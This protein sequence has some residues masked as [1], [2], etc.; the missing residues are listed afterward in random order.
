MYPYGGEAIPSCCY[1]N[2][3]VQSFIEE[4][5]DYNYYDYQYD[6]DSDYRDELDLNNPRS[7]THYN[8]TVGEFVSCRPGAFPLT[9]VTTLLWV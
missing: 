3:T 2:A 8:F 5:Y 7:I 9:S 6:F 4:S 1:L